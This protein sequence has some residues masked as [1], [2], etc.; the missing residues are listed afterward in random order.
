MRPR[1]EGKSA[2]VTGAGQ[3]IGRAIAL[4]LAAEGA[5]VVLVD[6]AAGPCAHVQEEIA[7]SG[8]QASAVAVDLETRA[9]AVEMVK[10]TLDLHA[11]VD[12]SVHNVG[13]TI[14]AKPF[15]EYEPEQIEREISRSLWPTLF[16]CREVSAV[17]VKQRAGA[18]V[19]VGSIATRGIY[20][21]PYAAAKGGVH[22]LTVA[23]AMELA[24][25]GVRVNCV[26]PGGVASPDR[27]TPRNPN[28]LTEQE[29]LWNQDVHEQTI[30]DTPL[31]RFGT[32]DEIAAAVCFLAADEASY[33]TGQVIFAAGGAVG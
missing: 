19:N 10:H 4:R 6:R 14:W 18:I 3:G 24:E 5:R 33:I 28:E 13:G 27:V 29:R 16:S 12:I 26:A 23:L 22:A 8:G 32:A 21:V 17:M 31:G 30:R 9:G 2:I 15:W 11:T 1:F 7:A 25:H 20:R